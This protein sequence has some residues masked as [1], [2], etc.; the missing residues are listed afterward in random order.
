MLDYDFTWHTIIA[1]DPGITSGIVVGHVAKGQARLV[2]GVQTPNLLKALHKLYEIYEPK[3][4]ENV[5]VCETFKVLTVGVKTVSLEGFG[6]CQ[7][8]A[9]VM[10]AR[11]YRQNP[12]MRK[13]AGKRYPIIKDVYDKM[14]GLEDSQIHAGDAMLHAF[15]AMYAH[16]KIRD[17]DFDSI[18]SDDFVLEEREFF[19]YLLKSKT[20]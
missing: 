4:C 11:F 7:M 6:A 17:F 15:T 9:L 13:F 3:T 10:N 1:V 18:R 20:I 14:V 19:D 8:L 12:D 16:M 5:I 2:A